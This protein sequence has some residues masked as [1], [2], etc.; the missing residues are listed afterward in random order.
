MHHL[1]FP[2]TCIICDGFSITDR[3]QPSQSLLYIRLEEKNE[4]LIILSVL[5]TIYTSDIALKSLICDSLVLECKKFQKREYAVL[6]FQ[7]DEKSTN[8]KNS[9][10]QAGYCKSQDQT[11]ILLSFNTMSLHELLLCLDQ[12]RWRRCAHDFQVLPFSNNPGATTRLLTLNANNDEQCQPI[13]NRSQIHL[14]RY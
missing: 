9:R 5:G 12:R 3:T 8:N 13:R 4:L 1:H 6:Q 14:Q 7:C 11:K 2:Y 10:Y